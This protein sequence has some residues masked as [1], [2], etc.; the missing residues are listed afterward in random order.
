MNLT[1][2]NIF[3]RYKWLKEKKR[4][5]IISADY[6]GL[7]C[8]SFLSHYLNWNLV[9]FYDFNS[10]WLSEEAKKNKKKIIWVD[11]NI[12]PKSGKSVGGQIVSIN[13]E[14]PIGFNTSCNANI[15]ANISAN[16]FKNKFPFSTLLFLMWLHN[17]EYNKK[18]IGQLLI[19]HSDNTWMK[20]QKYPQNVNYWTKVLTQYKWK[21]LFKNINELD[22]EKK[23]DSFFYPKLLTMGASSKFGRLTSIHLKIKSRECIFNP[24]WD[25]DI[26][27]KLFTLFADYLGWTPPKIPI[28]SKR[29]S[30]ERF[31]ESLQN[32]SEIGLEN[33]I[34]KK[35]IFSYAI[36]NPENFNYTIFKSYHS[37]VKKYK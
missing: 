17:V 23:I 26:I 9:G 16:N 3:K 34:D 12:L 21:K 29:I 6:D 11:L 22:F 10:I 27:L 35:K 2:K 14:T 28:I 18:D 7:I 37:N 8:A 31:K 20:I 19:L 32:I 1:R 36:T 33:F 25:T 24:D 30:G 15:L 13:G 5:F 4:H